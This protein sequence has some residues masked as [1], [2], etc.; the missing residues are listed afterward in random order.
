MTR[1][2]SQPMVRMAEL[3]IDPAVLDSYKTLL[4]EEI[5]ASIEA[6]PGVLTLYALSIKDDPAHI[7]IVEV[8][9]DQDAYDAHLR[10]PHFLR[11]KAL[12]SKMVRSLRLVETDPIILCSRANEGASPA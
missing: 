10:S 1:T 6:E 3:E 12:T 7:R 2:S 9:A 11:Y 5:E 8:Y 4:R